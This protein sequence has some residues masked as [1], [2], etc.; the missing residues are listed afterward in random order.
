[1][2]D[3]DDPA[4]HGRRLAEAS[5]AKLDPTSTAQAA[6][7][8]TM[9]ADLYQLLVEKQIL[10]QGDAIARWKKCR[11]PLWAPQT[12]ERREPMPSP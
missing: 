2:S 12:Q 10:T 7:A 9:F 8:V 5:A 11:S 3:G 1:M 6:A 4:E